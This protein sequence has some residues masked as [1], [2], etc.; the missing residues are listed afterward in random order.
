MKD[1]TPDPSG[2]DEEEDESDDED[3]E[4]PINLQVIIKE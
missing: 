1:V 4:D 3:G 2:A